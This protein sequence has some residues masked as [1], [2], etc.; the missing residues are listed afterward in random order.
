MQHSRIGTL[1]AVAALALFAAMPLAAD[2]A[3]TK[4]GISIESED[5]EFSFS[6]GGRIHFDAYA[7]DEDVV[8]TTGTTDFRRARLTLSGELYGWGYKLEQ[9]FSS[10]TTTAGFRDVYIS[11]KAAGGTFTIGQF[12]PYRSMEELTSSNEITM[13]ERPFASASGIYS[14]RQFVQGLGYKKGGDQYSFGVAVYNTRSAGDSRNEGVGATGRVTF[15]PVAS[16]SGVFHVGLSYSTENAN[17]GTPD[18]E[19]GVNYAGRRGPSLDIAVRPGDSGDTID[20]AGLELAGRA[21]PIYVQ[22]EY[23]TATVGQGPGLS[24]QDVDTYY[25]MAS[26]MLTGESKPYDAKSGV[27]KSA[28]P[29]NDYGAWELTARYDFIENKDVDNLEATMTTV[30]VNYYVNPKVRFM[31]NWSMGDATFAEVDE[32]TGIVTIVNDEP[33]QIALRTQLSF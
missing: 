24:D 32:E 1:A 11:K 12:K 28:K 23:A 6:L 33:D 16:D 5:G 30:G 20:T 22:G 18:G 14:G 13:M 27:F 8:S 17:D 21:G 4:G 31:L 10:G 26:W 19:I 7:F 3:E 25:V 29:E 2:E 15:A 9:D